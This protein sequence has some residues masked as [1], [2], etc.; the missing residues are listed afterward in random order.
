VLKN[1]PNNPIV[2]ILNLY[3]FGNFFSIWEEGSL[4]L[5]LYQMN[6]RQG[7]IRYKNPIPQSTFLLF[8]VNLSVNYIDDLSMSR[9]EYTTVYVGIVPFNDT[10]LAILTDDTSEYREFESQQF[11]F[12]LADRVIGPQ[13]QFVEVNWPSSRSILSDIQYV[14]SVPV[15]G[16]E[17]SNRLS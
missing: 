15:R 13:M 6:Y 7:H 10:Q 1:P 16:I 9:V 14:K 5:S 12:N 11:E 8:K 2:S 3:R 4:E 17:Y